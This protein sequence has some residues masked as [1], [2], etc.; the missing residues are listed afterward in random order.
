MRLCAPARA[1]LRRRF[2]PELVSS[3]SSS[4]LGAA[5]S[6]P[7]CRSGASYVRSLRA[8]GTVRPTLERPSTR[9]RSSEVPTAGSSFVVTTSAHRSPFSF[10]SLTQ[11]SHQLPLHTLTLLDTRNMKFLALA[12]VAAAFSSLASAVPMKRDESPVRPAYTGRL[13]SYTDS[14]PLGGNLSVSYI[15]SV[16]RRSPRPPRL[17]PLPRLVLT[18]SLV[19]AGSKLRAALPGGDSQRRSRPSRPGAHLHLAGRLRAVRHPRARDRPRHGRARRLGQHDRH[20][21]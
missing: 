2:R 10:L 19:R 13:V 12:A 1:L 14:V 6:G 17:P 5:I 16:R 4:S 18:S 7:A 15:A 11:T 8:Q 3:L 20:H 9:R 21:P